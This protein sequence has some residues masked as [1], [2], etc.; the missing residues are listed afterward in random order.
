M[1]KH[2][3]NKIKEDSYSQ[4]HVNGTD[5]HLSES[6]CDLISPAHRTMKFVPKGPINNIPALVQI[7]AWCWPGDKRLSE[8]IMIRL[9]THI[10]V[11][12][13]QWVQVQLWQ[14]SMALQGTC[15]EFILSSNLVKAHSS[16]NSVSVFRDF[17]LLEISLGL[18][19]MSLLAL[20]VCSCVCL[21]NCLCINHK[22]VPM[23][24]QSS[25]GVCVVRVLDMEGGGPSSSC[26]GHS[27]SVFFYHSVPYILI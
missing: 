20:C 8:P 19:V 16:N 26:G 11:T 23:I 17:F 7:M 24:I 4:A 10:C 1:N 18:W 12:R 9:P 22:L 3:S 25:Y 15:P 2:K 27:P 6:C 13:P 5:H 14:G 21:C